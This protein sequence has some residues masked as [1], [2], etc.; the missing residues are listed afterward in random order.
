MSSSFFFVA[1]YL[2][3]CREKKQKQAELQLLG[4]SILKSIHEGE[5]QGPKEARERPIDCL[6]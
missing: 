2:Q 4:E 3:P 1:I 6:S 5:K